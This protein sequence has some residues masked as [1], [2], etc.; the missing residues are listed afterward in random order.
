LQINISTLVLRAVAL[1]FAAAGVLVCI[2]VL[3]ELGAVI[4]V[5]HPKYAFW[6]YPVLVGLYAAAACFF[7]ALIH[8]W[9]M[10]NSIDRDELPTQRSM[11]AIRVSSIIF[12]VLFFVAAMPAIYVLAEVNDAP[13]AILLGT[14]L[15]VLPMAAAAIIAILERIVKAAMPRRGERKH[16]SANGS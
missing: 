5:F 7:Y 4:P 11:K 6:Q 9:L 10:L 16:P 15:G 12:T 1:L 13:G 8:F 14:A 3:P 2:F